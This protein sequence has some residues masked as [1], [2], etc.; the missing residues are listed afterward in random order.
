MRRSLI[1]AAGLV[2]ACTR[3]GADKGEGGAA[4]GSKGAG[5]SSPASDRPAKPEPEPAEPESPRRHESGPPS[6]NDRPGAGFDCGPRGQTDCCAIRPVAGGRFARSYDGVTC[7]D[8]GYPATVGDF[9][10]DVHEVTVGR[11]RAF[12]DAGGGVRGGAPEP[13]AGAHPKIESSGWQAAWSEK[14]AASREALERE[15]DCAPAAT[16]TAAPG[17]HE[18]LPIN[19]LSFYEAH[20]FCAWDGGYLPTE[21]E[22]NHVASGGDEQRVYPWSTPPES[23][24]ISPRHAVFGSPGTA[25]VGARSPLGDGRWG[26]ADLAGNVWEWTLDEV[27]PTKVLPTE[28][29]DFCAPAGMPLPC[30]DCVARGAGSARV[31]RGGGW[32]LPERGMAV[33]IRRGADPME[34]AHVF[35]V[36]CARPLGSRS[37]AAAGSDPGPAACE[38]SCAGRAC[39]S[40]GCGGSC[41]R[42]GASSRCVEHRCESFSYP[43]GPYGLDEGQVVPDLALLAIEDATRNPDAMREL[44]IHDYAGDFPGEKRGETLLIYLATTWSKHDPSAEL[45]ELARER[46]VDLLVILLEGERRGQ[47]ADAGNLRFFALDRRLDVPVAMDVKLELAEHLG[48]PLEPL[49]LVV[50]RETMAVRHRAGLSAKLDPALAAKL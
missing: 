16:W 50:D 7:S 36:R 17:D 24:A 39:G 25:P 32:G 21:A 11:F 18:R 47:P 9:E 27:D 40:D 31:L 46:G 43:P 8:R 12:L 26:H 33:A 15:L 48:A 29:A 35:G 14:L 10:L 1:V 28:G 23:T 30:E 42:C 3:P 45:R 22:R 37:R 13:G 6:C 5:A 49:I 4:Q 19:C 34:R 38:P 44:A 20:A 2:L 41:G